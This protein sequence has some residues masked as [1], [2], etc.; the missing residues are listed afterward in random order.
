MSHAEVRKVWEES[1][2]WRTDSCGGSVSE[3]GST[4]ESSV[5]RRVRASVTHATA[6]AILLSSPGGGVWLNG[7]NI[8]ATL[9]SSFGCVDYCVPTPSHHLQLGRVAHSTNTTHQYSATPSR[10]CSS[11]AITPFLLTLASRQ[12]L[13]VKSLQSQIG[14]S[15]P[16]PTAQVPP[17]YGSRGVSIRLGS[18]WP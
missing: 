17:E 3:G 8:A 10:I 13:V 18:V 11:K 9:S 12:R 7:P 16:S 15:C 14:V 4:T 5:I 1:D 2:S 6:R